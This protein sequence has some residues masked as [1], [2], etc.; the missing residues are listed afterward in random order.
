MH[1]STEAQS[2]PLR[3]PANTLTPLASCVQMGG[4]GRAWLGDE[5]GLRRAL[6]L[7]SFITDVDGF[8]PADPEPY[9]RT[10]ELCVAPRLGVRG[11]VG[12][13]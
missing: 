1:T 4:E 10:P 12:E 13:G 5:K 2:P 7:F 11:S 3:R 9:T 6:L 8:C